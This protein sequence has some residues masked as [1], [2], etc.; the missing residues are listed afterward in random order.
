MV[1]QVTVNFWA[2][3]RDTSAA[4]ALSSFILSYS[5][6]AISS[7]VASWD[8][9]RSRRWYN[10]D[11]LHVAPVIQIVDYRYLIHGTLK[12]CRGGGNK[13]GLREDMGGRGW[14]CSKNKKKM[15]FFDTKKNKMVTNW[16]AVSFGSSGSRPV[17][18]PD[19]CW[20]PWASHLVVWRRTWRSSYWIMMCHKI[21]VH[22]ETFRRKKNKYKYKINL[23]NWLGWYQHSIPPV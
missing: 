15:S 11:A 4:A 22:Q 19:W 17:T 6:V 20:H 16:K 8:R 10:P 14:C 2:H 9:W 13:N 23:S 18:L 12:G 7:A 5:A 3:V 21:C 1:T